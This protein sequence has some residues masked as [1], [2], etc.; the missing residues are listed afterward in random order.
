MAKK[1]KTLAEALKKN[2]TKKN[3][4]F[5]VKSSSDKTTSFSPEA[6]QTAHDDKMALPVM[7]TIH[8][9]LPK[10]NPLALKPVFTYINKA[11]KEALLKE[12]S[13]KAMYDDGLYVITSVLFKNMPKEYQVKY[14]QELAKK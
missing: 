3:Q 13:F 12:S 2:N 4:Y 5:S 1:N 9:M 11:E 14:N 6:L 10:A 8:G 7:V